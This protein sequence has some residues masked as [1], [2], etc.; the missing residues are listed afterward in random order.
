MR[1]AMKPNILLLVVGWGAPDA[2][3]DTSYVES[4][5]FEEVLPND[6]GEVGVA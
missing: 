3:A 5:A 4:I 2:A 1:F 6:V